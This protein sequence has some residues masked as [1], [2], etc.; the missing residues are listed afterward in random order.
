MPLQTTPR[1]MASTYVS[2]PEE[3][4]VPN[5]VNGHLSALVSGGASDQV[6]SHFEDLGGMLGSGGGT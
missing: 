2:A 1:P 4:G 3:D 6:A 5:A